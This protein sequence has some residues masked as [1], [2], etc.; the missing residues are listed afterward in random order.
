MSLILF[1]NN[2]TVLTKLAAD[3][4]VIDDRAMWRCLWKKSID[5]SIQIGAQVLNKPT[6]WPQLFEREWWT[7]K[8]F[9]KLTFVTPLFKTD[10]KKPPK[11]NSWDSRAPYLVAYG[12]HVLTE[13]RSGPRRDPLLESG[14]VFTNIVRIL[15]ESSWLSLKTFQ[16]EWFRKNF[17]LSEVRLTRMTHSLKRFDWM[18]KKRE[19][20]KNTLLD[21]TALSVN[22]EINIICFS[23]KTLWIVF[24]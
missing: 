15:S 4:I 3:L 1:S 16:Q 17:D 22:S 18:I 13:N 14:A 11:K 2:N 23:I 20:N 7:V 9:S 8:C 12:H 6:G 19:R 10:L 24:M 5:M 21:F